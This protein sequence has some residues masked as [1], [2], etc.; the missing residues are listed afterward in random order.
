MLR[1]VVI[2][3]DRKDEFAIVT[4]AVKAHRFSCFNLAD[5]LTRCTFPNTNRSIAAIRRHALSI[6]GN[7]DM[8][9]NSAVTLCHNG[10]FALCNV[11]HPDDAVLPTGRKSF[12]IGTEGN[13]L[14]RTMMLA[15]E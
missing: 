4:D 8:P 13:G 2:T 15:G 11:P 7:R 6:G 10:F 3:N 5:F 14:H 12:A 1:F 9:N